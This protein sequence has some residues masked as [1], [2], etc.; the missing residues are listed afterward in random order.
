MYTPEFAA[1]PHGTYE[2]M[3]RRHGSLVPVL[4]DPDVPATLVIGYHT[5]VQI[6]HDPERF[7]ADP[8]RWEERV[9]ADNPV[10]PMME[11]RPNAL[12]SAGIEHARYRGANV[13]S[14]G[15]VDLHG[16]RTVVQ[17]VAIGLI[18]DLC[19]AGEADL[20]TQYAFP[21]AFQV[22]N[23][24]LGCPPEIGERVAKGMAS[25]FEGIDAEAGNAMLAAALAELVLLKKAHPAN[26][27]TSRLLQH[28]SG[29]DVTEMV[30]QLA[31]IYGAGIEPQQNLIANTLLLILTD[32]RFSG[33]VLDGNLAVRDALDEVLYQDPP[34]AN[35]A[36]SYPPYPVQIDGVWLPADQPVLISMSA[37]NNDP[38]IASDQRAGNRAHLAWSIGPHACPAQSAAYLIAQA[39]IDQILDALPE[40][41]L[42]VP[43]EQL[44]W[45]PGPFARALAALPVTVPGSPPIPLR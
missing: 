38:A 31:C 2:E 39:A 36:I 26:D 1:D 25:I 9:A 19:Q 16:L 5:A 37:C 14:L 3:R 45:R 4:L 33:D 6:L 10:R 24:L 43:A 44:V 12:R 18:N 29:L 15:G 41:E 7:P 28:E 40:M 21:L 8:R 13:F 32:E 20:I 27:V 42:A 30:H 23:T 35:Y 22:L 11:W 17:D 34:M